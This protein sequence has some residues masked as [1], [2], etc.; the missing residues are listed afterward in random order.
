MP[1]WNNWSGKLA[2]KPNDIVFLRSEADARALAAQADR[3]GRSIR[4]AGATHSHAPLVL[5]DDIIAN[6]QG[7]AGVES[8]DAQ[9]QSAWVGA[10]SRIFTLGNALHR[11][12][13]ALHNQGDIDQQA[14]GG[15]TATG[16]HGTG[17]NLRNLSSAVLGAR[18][19][20]ADGS[21]VA[22][23]ANHENALWE[24]ARLHL[25]AFGIV[26]ALQLQ[27][28]PVYR[29][30]ERGWREPLDDLLANVEKHVND[31]RHFEFFWYPRTDEASAKV[32]NET[33]DACVYPLAA[34]GERCAWSHEVL[35]NHRP[36]PHTEMEY[37]IPAAHGPACMRAIAELLEQTFSDI[38]WPVEYRTLA[39]D[40]VWLSTAC[41]RDTVTISVH[42]DVRLDDEPYF[43]ACEEIFLHYEGRPHW[44]KV[45][46]LNAQQLADLHPHWADWWRVRDAVDPNGTF[47][48]QYLRDLRP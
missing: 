48:N 33:E 46:Y 2:A 11:H 32:I 5:H 20:L 15:A 8:V 4:T 18:I 35:P 43:R 26:T 24:A 28:R 44:G 10:G 12:G 40:D 9:T 23:D 42:Q 14:I 1:A 6:A 36:H 27:L 29:L 30:R 7:L 3:A 25:G 17:R 41:G 38:Q 37:S 22:C 31:N 21:V 13:L 45:N 39:T 47:L 34:E 19:A 16:T